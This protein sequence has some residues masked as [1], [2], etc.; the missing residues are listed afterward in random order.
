MDKSKAAIYLRISRDIEGD[1]HGVDSQL[2]R[3]RKY[4]EQ[5]ELNVVKV[6]E[7]NDITAS[8]TKTRPQFEQLL[9]DV[10]N[11]D[12]SLVLAVD[13]DR[14]HRNLGD[15]VR[16]NEALAAGGAALVTINGG[17]VDLTTSSGILQADIMA[18]VHANEVR[19]MSERGLASQEY[20]AGLGLYRGPA[21]FGYA[22]K[23]KGVI[24]P[25]PDEAAVV[26]DVARRILSGESLM[27]IAKRVEASGV[28]S[29]QGVKWTATTIRKMVLAPT[30]AGLV[31]R[32]GEILGRGKWDPNIDEAD[33]YQIKALLE[34]PARRTQQGQ[35]RRWQGSGV[36]KCG[37]CGAGLKGKTHKHRGNYTA[38]V[39]PNN[40]LTVNQVVLDEFIEDVV[41][42]YLDK[43][44]NRLEVSRGDGDEL[45][46]LL[47]ER[48]ALMQRS[49]EL[50]ALVATGDIT[51][52]QLKRANKVIGEKLDEL[53]GRI[54]V[55]QEAGAPVAV[56]LD[57]EDVRAAWGRL[58]ADKRALII[59]ALMDVTINR[60][61]HRGR[62]FDY[63]RV[64]I[65]WK[66]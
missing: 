51:P 37:V 49:D 54:A 35:E 14:L 59:D 46:A 60:A 13:T 9:K 47:D 16:L 45:P 30:Q 36:Y 5:H 44:E 21:P 6:Y 58:S 26:K 48:R 55:L 33:W 39:C 22:N 11:K 4:A 41:V 66:A 1:A 40:H 52:A 12:V 62:E 32:H 15:Y 43:P 53:N 3:C 28:K 20:R 64:N 25:I 17:V 23:G 24:E 31:T 61:S 19:H 63:S 10:A 27:S 65:E 38:Y 29:R 50:G 42:G 57:A 7:D 8:G 56:L 18:S 2:L 34:D